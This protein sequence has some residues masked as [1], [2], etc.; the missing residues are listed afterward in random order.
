MSKEFKPLAYY[1]IRRGW[2]DQLLRLCDSVISKKGK[3][4]LSIYWKAFALGM[5]G[6]IPDALRQLEGFQSRRDLQFP[7]SMA[8]LYFHERAPNVDRDAVDA[9]NAELS[10]AEDV[11]V[12][13]EWELLLLFYTS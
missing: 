10:I 4:P 3:D 11:T 1:L 5:S 12:S 9:L 7:V 2:H 6:N 8:L 13:C